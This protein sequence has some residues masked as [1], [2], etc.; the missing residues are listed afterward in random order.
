MA[1]TVDS[2]QVRAAVRETYGRIATE[3]R[4]AGCCGTTGCCGPGAESTSEALGYS[5]EALWALVSVRGSERVAL[6]G[7][8]PRRG[9]RV[10]G[11]AVAAG[12]ERGR[13]ERSKSGRLSSVLSPPQASADRR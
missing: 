5:D 8:G 6:G 3:E 4:S 2:E 12:H 9:C 1:T 13:L 11:D 10:G 7:C